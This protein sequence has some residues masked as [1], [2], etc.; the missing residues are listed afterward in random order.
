LIADAFDELRSWGADLL[1][2]VTKDWAKDAIELAVTVWIVPRIVKHLRRKPDNP[3]AKSTADRLEAFSAHRS[4]KPEEP[5]SPLVVMSLTGC[6]LAQAKSTLHL[7][8]YEA[9]GEIWLV[10]KMDSWQ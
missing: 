4:E 1:K 2:D 10:V 7:A 5:V 6:T 8:G 9:H 3:I